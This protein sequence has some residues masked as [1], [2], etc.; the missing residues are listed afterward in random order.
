MDAA[1]AHLEALAAPVL[2]AWASQWT[3][4]GLTLAQLEEATEW[5]S[6]A[7]LAREFQAPYRRARLRFLRRKHAPPFE[8]AR[9]DR[10]A[11]DLDALP[12]LTA[13]LPADPARGILWPRFT[14]GE[15]KA[16]TLAAGL[17][18]LALTL[19]D[20]VRVLLFT[21]HGGRTAFTRPSVPGPGFRVPAW[22]WP[23]VQAALSGEETGGR[24]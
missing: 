12:T 15:G 4:A 20:G 7:W 19:P 16:Y 14:D 3:A 10:V 17:G 8:P 18:T 2:G 13:F 21:G 6:G 5:A 9:P 1:Q 11:L 24:P 23:Q 22:L